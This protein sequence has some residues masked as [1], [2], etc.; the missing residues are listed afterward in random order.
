MQYRNGSGI[1]WYPS[2]QSQ[3]GNNNGEESLSND[4][5]R[6]LR[7]ASITEDPLEPWPVCP[8]GPILGITKNYEWYL[9]M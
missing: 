4:D 6:G 2:K 9:S 1:G 5:C 3:E 8:R 7:T